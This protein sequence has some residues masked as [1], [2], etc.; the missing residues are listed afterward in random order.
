MAGK[1]IVPPTC[2]CGDALRIDRSYN[3]KETARFLGITV[4]V[5]NLRYREGHI[6]PIF[7][8]GDRRYSGYMIARLLGWPLSDN[9]QDYVPWESE[10]T[11]G[12]FI[13]DERVPAD[14]GLPDVVISDLGA[15]AVAK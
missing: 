3:D 14:S 9:H 10:V 6:A 8:V 11:E 12:E 4:F 7:P 2:A 5:L 13:E 15:G 1:V